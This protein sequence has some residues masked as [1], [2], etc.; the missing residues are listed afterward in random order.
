MVSAKLLNEDRKR[1]N[2]MY[3]SSA[4]NFRESSLPKLNSK[5][6]QRLNTQGNSVSNTNVN[7]GPRAFNENKSTNS[8]KPIGSPLRKP[9]KDKK[10]NIKKF[11]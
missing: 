3:T 4:S 7:S 1:N 11:S 5:Q 6:G 8:I 10:S 2:S 9:T